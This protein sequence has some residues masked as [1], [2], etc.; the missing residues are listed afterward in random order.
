M[1][2]K[3]LFT[4]A[5]GFTITSGGCGS[6]NGGAN[7]SGG[8]TGT[9][10]A[11]GGTINGGTTSSGGT[12]T[13]GTATGGN[14]SGGAAMGG[15]ST[16]GTTGGGG[17]TG[18]A[19]TGGSLTGGKATGGT[20]TG[21]SATGGSA[22]GG[23][24]AGNGGTSAGGAGGSAT[25]GA[26][27]SSSGYPLGNTA[28]PSAGCG[29]ALSSFTKGNATLKMRSAD[30]DREYIVGI[31]QN[32]DPNTPYRLV[33]GMHPMGGSDTGVRDDHWYNLQQLDTKGNTIWVAPQ[34]YTDGAPWRGG[35][36]KDHVFFEN[37]VKL[38][39]S[40]LCIDTSRV[41][42]LGWSFGSMI[43]NSLAQTHQD[44][45]RGVVVY[46]TAD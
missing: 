13:G 38:L 9:G 32:Y 23:S 14:V 24:S 10:G 40:E 28:V 39:K 5:L 26:G 20:A 43:T 21:G 35:D 6:G 44:V 31:P 37:I 11:T 46:S 33:F 19:A 18:G 45:L 12:T 1:Y 16:G 8:S 2:R 4:L 42:S 15:T 41:F 3:F 22:T 25:G 27:G 36:N 34:G 29:K 7:A 30:L 17:A